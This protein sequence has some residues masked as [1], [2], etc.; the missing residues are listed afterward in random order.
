VA[1]P[2][3]VRLR[4]E[5]ALKIHRIQQSQFLPLTLDEA[6]L[7]FATPKNLEAMTPPFLNFRILSDVPDVVHSGLMI[8]YRIR[9]VFGIPMR[10]LTEIK[11]VEKRT[12]FVDEQ[13]I[14]PF[15]FWYHEH[16]FEAVEG[17]IVMEDEVHYV[18]PWSILGGFIH[19]VFIRRRLLEIFRFRKCYLTERFADSARTK[20]L[21]S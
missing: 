16:R 4:K 19:W 1:D 17:G 3:K 15:P 13:R 10:W 21:P 9:A 6:W 12:R 7:F 11:H 2:S 5:I 18:M 14:G 20:S 8:E